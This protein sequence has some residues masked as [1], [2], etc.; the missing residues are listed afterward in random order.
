MLQ[1]AVVTLKCHLSKKALCNHI[2]KLSSTRISVN[3]Q[4]QAESSGLSHGTEGGKESP[5]SVRG[6]RSHW[7]NI[8]LR[9]KWRCEGGDLWVIGAEHLTTEGAERSL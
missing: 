9:I 4:R 3:L 8:N 1:P 7:P 5:E 6:H 2:T